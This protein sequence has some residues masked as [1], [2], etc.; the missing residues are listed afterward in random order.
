MRNQIYK[1]YVTICHTL[2]RVWNTVDD[3][4]AD[5]DDDDDDDLLHTEY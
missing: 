3:D 1:P 5:D 4:D 2:I